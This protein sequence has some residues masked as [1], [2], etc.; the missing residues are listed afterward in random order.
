ME[1]WHLR[2]CLEMF[3]NVFTLNCA[4]ATSFQCRL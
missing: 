3:L 1:R 2:T 4:C